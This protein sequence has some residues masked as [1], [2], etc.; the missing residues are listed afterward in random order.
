MIFFTKGNWNRFFTHNKKTTIRFHHV[1]EGLHS[2]GSGS[3]LS[4]T[5]KHLGK[6][7]IGK[8]VEPEG[9][10]V[11]DLTEHDAMDDGFD[12]LEELMKELSIIKF[13][14]PITPETLGWRYPAVVAEGN[15]CV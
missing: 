15:R 10:F 5:Y 9:K 7:I 6:V 14:T 8:A 11:K 12:S 3:R 2:A 1:M 13:S 4:G